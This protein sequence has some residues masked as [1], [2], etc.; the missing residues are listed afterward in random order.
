MGVPSLFRTLVQQ[1]PKIISNVERSKCD[2]LLMDFNCLIHGCKENITPG[3]R[4]QEEELITEVISY[5]S[6]IICNIVKPQKVVYIAVDGPVPKAKMDKQRLRRFKKVSDDY[7]ISKLKT[8]YDK[9]TTNAFNSNKI[10]PG[11][12]FMDYL[13]KYI[14]WYIKKRMSQ[15]S[16]W[17]NLDIIF[18]FILL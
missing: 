14:D 18:S 17:K 1:Y 15:S 5:T 13:T 11:T 3:S 2:Y 16:V 4:N 6:D 12:K 9:D 10:T 8:K 7:Y